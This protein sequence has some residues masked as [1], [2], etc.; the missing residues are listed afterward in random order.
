[1]KPANKPRHAAG[2]ARPAAALSLC[3]LIAV[4]LALTACSPLQMPTEEA[5]TNWELDPASPEP[6]AT[7]KDITLHVDRPTAIAALATRAMA[8]RERSLQRSYYAHNRWVDEPARMLHPHLVRAIED[9]GVV[10]GVVSTSATASAAYRLETELL[11]LEH[12]YRELEHGRARIRLRARLVDTGRGTVVATR[13]FEATEP[14]RETG[15]AGG[16]TAANRA[17]E[18]L[19]EELVAWLPGAVPGQP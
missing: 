19:L 12:D 3:T 11:E 13:R 1:M 17:L 16:V 7:Q 8:Y 14:S 15:P 18:R 5:A 4:A 6:V 9:A 2:R 10:T